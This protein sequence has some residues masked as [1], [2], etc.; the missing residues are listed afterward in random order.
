MQALERKFQFHKGT[1]KTVDKLNGAEQYA[2]HFNSIK[3]QLR[4]YAYE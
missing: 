1:I 3:V 4:P 2:T